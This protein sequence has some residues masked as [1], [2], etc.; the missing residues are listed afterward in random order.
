YH[1]EYAY[2]CMGYEIPAAFGAK[3]ALGD[4]HE[5]VAIVGDGTYQML[6]QEIATIVSEGVKVI[7]VLLQNHGFASI[8]GLSESRGSQ[9]FGTQY[10][11][12]S[13]TSGRLDG[14]NVPFDL[15]ANAA[16]WGADVLRCATIADF[17]ANYATAAASDHTTVLYIE[18]DLYGPNPPGSAWWD[19]PVSQVSDLESTQTAYAEYVREKTA[20]RHYL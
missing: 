9:R 8:G 12:R 5:V 4:G 15:A 13:R 3:L 16:S 20:Q 18:T 6:P 17:R 14:E 2:S 1:V 19:V 11:M 7:I 10:R